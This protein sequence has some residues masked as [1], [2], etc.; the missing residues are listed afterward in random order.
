MCLHRGYLGIFFFRM[1]FAD[2]S[3]GR[4][5]GG[6]GLFGTTRPGGL[7]GALQSAPHKRELEAPWGS[8][9]YFRLTCWCLKD[10]QL[11]LAERWHPP[12]HWT[13][14]SQ[15][16]LDWPNWTAPFGRGYPSLKAKAST[17]SQ[18]RSGGGGGVLSLCR[19]QDQTH[20]PLPSSD[21]TA[22]PSS[23]GSVA[24]ES[25][26]NV[27]ITSFDSAPTSEDRDT[28]LSAK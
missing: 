9:Q 4:G 10:P 7:M 15:P 17:W 3:R 12:P 5:G 25:L 8:T 1:D 24:P 21:C 16:P 22:A 19:G 23:G 6:A 26:S 20:S 11:L 13:T 14:L 28:L 27:D 2:G 18:M